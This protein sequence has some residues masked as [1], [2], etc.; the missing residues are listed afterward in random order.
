MMSMFGDFM[1]KVKHIYQPIKITRYRLTQ[2]EVDLKQYNVEISQTLNRIKNMYSVFMRTQKMKEQHSGRWFTKEGAS[3]ERGQR[4]MKMVF[5]MTDDNMRGILNTNI[6]NKRPIKADDGNEYFPNYKYENILKLMRCRS[7]YAVNNIS[8]FSNPLHFHLKWMKTIGSIHTLTLKKIAT[9]IEKLDWNGPQIN[10]I[11]DFWRTA[12]STIDKVTFPRCHESPMVIRPTYMSLFGL[13]TLG[14]P[15]SWTEES[16]EL[17]IKE[18]VTGKFE[19]TY[20][21]QQF[22]KNKLDQWFSDWSSQYNHS[23]LSYHEYVTDLN[24]WATSGGA[25]S[26]K[27]TFSGEETKIRSKWAWGLEH[28]INGDIHQALKDSDKDAGA[29]IKEEEKTRVII[30]TP[31]ESYVRQCYLL[32]KMGRTRFLN[33][34][35]TDKTRVRNLLLSKARHYICVDASKFDHNV[36]K[37]F[38]LD[39]IARIA[40]IGLIKRDRD[41]YEQAMLEWNAIND[42]KVKYLGKK[43]QYEKGILS[44]WRITSLIGSML[45]ALICERVKEDMRIPF[46]YCV[47]GDDIIMWTDADIDPAKIFRIIE[48]FGIVINKRKSTIST[49][50]E[51]LKYVYMDNKAFGFPCRCIRAIF[52]ANPWLDTSITSEASEVANK[53]HTYLSRLTLTNNS[54]PADLKPY[55]YEAAKDINGWLG[56][57]HKTGVIMKLFNTPMSCGGLGTIETLTDDAHIMTYRGE[58]TQKY[59]DVKEKFFSIFGAHKDNSKQVIKKISVKPVVLMNMVRAKNIFMKKVSSSTIE[60]VMTIP[61]DCNALRSYLESVVAINGCPKIVK[62]LIVNC[63]G[64]TFDANMMLPKMFRYTHNW[65][66]KLKALYEADTVA[67]PPSLYLDNRYDHDLNKRLSNMVRIFVN[68]VDSMSVGNYRVASMYAM[69]LF[70]DS[71]GPIHSL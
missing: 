5:N 25:P 55:Y 14:G 30:T 8:T 16:I 7:P 33:S 46:E 22:S 31:M 66:E 20:D 71:N 62:D 68:N 28:M 65:Y 13:S 9:T 57:R 24:R 19:W 10:Y 18:W 26:V 59:D 51:F 15:R 44:G 11:D 3:H 70:L 43:F 6:N 38:I 4:R 49:S 67:M 47:Q 34:T 36:P 60:S 12:L 58:V 64:K 63:S 40:N 37:A 48:T 21:T 54:V 29:A 50:G 35:I 69:K 45:S 2:T 17:K 39:I 53:W 42:L 1:S 61:N 56:G 32:Y 52:Y 23:S 41:L 27:L